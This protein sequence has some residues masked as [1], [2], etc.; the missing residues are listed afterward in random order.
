LTA[1]RIYSCRSAFAKGI[2]ILLTELLEWMQGISGCSR[3]VF[4]RHYSVFF[5][6]RAARALPNEI[7]DEEKKKEAQNSVT[8][9]S[10]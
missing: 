9:Y 10:Y 8:H 7:L 6:K 2:K 5:K 3:F 4:P 1:D